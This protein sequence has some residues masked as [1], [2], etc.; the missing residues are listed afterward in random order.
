MSDYEKMSPSEA[1]E[2]RRMRR[3]AFLAVVVST[4]AV[5]ASVVSLP[6]VYNYVQGLQSHMMSE[7]DFCKSRSRDMWVEMYALQTTKGTGREKRAWLLVNRLV[8]FKLVDMV[9][10]PCQ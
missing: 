5:V 7:V 8:E 2:L 6:M 3:V 1:E 10:H 9:N 4:V